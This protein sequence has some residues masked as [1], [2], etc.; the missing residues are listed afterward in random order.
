MSKERL[1]QFPDQNTKFGISVSL[2]NQYAEPL[3]WQAKLFRI[4]TKYKDREPRDGSGNSLSG[5][6]ETKH[7]GLSVKLTSPQENGW[8]KDL[9]LGTTVEKVDDNH[10]AIMIT[11]AAKQPSAK[12][13]KQSDGQAISRGI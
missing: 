4:L 3:K 2:S 1:R 13:G 8:S 9:Y 10:A 6:L 12:N 5:S 11:G 7:T